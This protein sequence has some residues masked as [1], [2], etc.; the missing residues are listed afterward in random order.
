MIHTEANKLTRITPMIP[1]A[2]LKNKENNQHHENLRITAKKIIN[3][4]QRRLTKQNTIHNYIKELI[5]RLA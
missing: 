1:C 3:L 4:G 5:F 2:I